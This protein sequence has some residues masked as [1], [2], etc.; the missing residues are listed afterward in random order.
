MT[1]AA[2]AYQETDSPT[3]RSKKPGTVKR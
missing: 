1:V 3:G 2:S